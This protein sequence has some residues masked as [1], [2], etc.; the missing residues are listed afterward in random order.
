[1][2]PQA[3]STRDSTSGWINGAEPDFW[4]AGVAGRWGPEAIRFRVLEFIRMSGSGTKAL[5]H[6]FTFIL[7]WGIPFEALIFQYTPRRCL[8]NIPL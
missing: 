4:G 2:A 1:M 3:S 5:P 7:F 8:E 6:E